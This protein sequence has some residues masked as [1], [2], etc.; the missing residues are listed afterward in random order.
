VVAHVQHA[1][2]DAAAHAAARQRREVVDL[3]QR[4]AVTVR[5]AGDGLNTGWSERAARLA[6]RRQLPA[7][8]HQRHEVGLLGLAM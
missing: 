1:P 3:V 5:L 7:P 2:G 6:A 8:R 4:D